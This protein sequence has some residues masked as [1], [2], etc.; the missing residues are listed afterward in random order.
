MDRR[1]L[2]SRDAGWAKALSRRLAATSVTPNQISIASM[3]FA[4]FAGLAFWGVAQTGGFARV[5]LLLVAAL[6]CQLRL[7][8]NLMDGLVAIEAGKQAKDGPFWNEFP[9]RIADILIFAGLGL[10][11]GQPALGWAAAVMAVLAAYTRELGRTCG[12]AADF[13]GPMAKPHRMA[14]VTGAAVLAGFEGVWAGQGG[15]LTAALWVLVVGTAVTVARR[16]RRIITQLQA[17]G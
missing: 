6:G 4:A 10:A 16:S 9:D 14:L 3:A 1:P 17:R 11:V 12:L 13:S 8:C 15:V 5:F 7:V 2:N